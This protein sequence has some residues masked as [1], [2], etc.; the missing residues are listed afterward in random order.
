MLH[1]YLL[2]PAPDPVP[3]GVSDASEG[4]SIH[5]QG[6][7]VEGKKMTKLTALTTYLAGQFRLPPG[8]RLGWDAELLELRRPDGSLVAVFNVWGVA[9]AAVARAAEEDYRA[10]GRSTA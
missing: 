7:A 1:H 8:Y 2:R 5:V 4:W 3:D 9:P 6:I 10:N